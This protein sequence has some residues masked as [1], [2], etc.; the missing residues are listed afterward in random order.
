METTPDAAARLDADTLTTPDV[1]GRELPREWTAGFDLGRLERWPLAPSRERQAHDAADLLLV[2]T[3]AGWVADGRDPSPVAVLHDQHGAVALP[4]L[5][6]GLDVRLGVDEA[7]A[8]RSAAH[9]LDLFR[10]ADGRLPEAVEIE[11]HPWFIGV[12]AHPELK[13]KPFEPAPL[14]R[15]FVR[16]AKDQERMV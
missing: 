5:A 14:F 9:N 4:L 7:S 10:D 16:A 12:Q 6:R 3:L 2:D 1:G 13:S 11:G 8:A 15:D